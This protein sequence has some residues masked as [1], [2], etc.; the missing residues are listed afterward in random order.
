MTIGR[1]PGL[2]PRVLSTQLAK[3]LPELR[4][5]PGEFWIAR[6]PTVAAS[7]HH[8]PDAQQVGHG[9]RREHNERG[10]PGGNHRLLSARS[11]LSWSS[12]ARS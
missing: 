3:L 8:G 9:N 5:L 1:D 10:E 7:A 11:A 4:E 6:R 2:V 12:S